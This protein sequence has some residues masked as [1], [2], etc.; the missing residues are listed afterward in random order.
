M[1]N[2]KTG[3]KLQKI[4]NFFNM[5]PFCNYSRYAGES[6]INGRSLLGKNIILIIMAKVLKVKVPFSSLEVGDTF[7]KRGDVYVSEYTRN[8][9][10][11]KDSEY[12]SVYSSTYTISESY[13]K[14]LCAIGYLEG[15]ANR[16]VT[17]KVNAKRKLCY[18]HNDIEK[19]GF[20]KIS[21]EKTFQAADKIITVSEECKN[22]LLKNFPEHKT[23]FEIVENITGQKILIEESKKINAYPD[24][25]NEIIICTVGRFSPQ[26]NISL[27]VDCCDELV[28]RGRNIKWYHI[29]T[30]ELKAQIEKQIE[31]C[32]LEK[33]FILLGA[34]SKPYPYIG[35]CDIYVQPSL[36]EGKS[37]AIDE[38][39]AL[40]RPIV[41]T[42]FPTVFDQINDGVDG[43]ICHMD[44]DDMADKLELLIDDKNER[45]K[46]SNNLA[47]E[48]VSNEEEIFKLYGLIG[49]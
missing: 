32:G 30:G 47:G 40:L 3:K 15:N 14:A 41:V 9:E 35:Q 45:T 28:K 18:I 49:E 46:L 31:S 27:A 33:N 21:Y 44:K 1:Y 2:D 39:K 6:G 42:D 13:A 43:I 37:I 19:L 24:R 23:K 20:D 4:K 25:E 10:F 11:F 7:E 5:Q 48:K 8:D 26:K 12:S 22:S 17:E 36:F 29:G 16:F 38:A 34:N